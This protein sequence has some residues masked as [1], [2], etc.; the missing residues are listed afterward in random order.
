M[1]LTRVMVLA[2]L[3]VS[4]ACYQYAPYSP[5]EVVPG[6]VVRLRLSPE[7]ASKYAD[8]RLRNPRLLD[9][10]V[11]D[12]SG[13]ELMLDA[14]MSVGEPGANVRVLTQRVSVPVTGVLDVELKQLDRGRTSFLIGGGA[15]VL[16]VIVAKGVKGSGS[17]QGPGTE[18][19]EARRVPFWQLRLSF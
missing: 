2:G 8:L 5:Q 18:N 16:G 11:V 14:S 15:I 10:T 6:Q 4:G 9:G 17:D 3:S 7:E 19:P 12:R 1:R 13:S